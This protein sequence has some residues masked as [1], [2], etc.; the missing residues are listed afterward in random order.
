MPK[1]KSSLSIS[2]LTR[3]AL[4]EDVAVADEDNKYAK[5]PSGEGTLYADNL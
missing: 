5:L 4:D 1:G 3:R 2:A